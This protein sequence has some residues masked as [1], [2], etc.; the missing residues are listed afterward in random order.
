MNRQEGT[1]MAFRT[2]ET[3][4]VSV[5][6]VTLL[7]LMAAPQS[8]EPPFPDLIRLP[9]DFGPESI[10]AGK[11]HIFYVGSLAPTTLGQILVGDRQTGTV[12]ELVAP[13]GR[14]AA[15][16]K[17]DPRSDLLFVAGGPSGRATVYDAAS[18]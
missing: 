3:A 11:G 17:F 9:A 1:E 14:V 8:D 16:M 15:G 2:V 4:V 10:A 12:R 13:T 7:N 5:F 6:A 18:G